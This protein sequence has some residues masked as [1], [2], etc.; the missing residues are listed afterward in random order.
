MVKKG[1]SLL[2]HVGRSRLGRRFS[3]RTL[4]TMLTAHFDESCGGGFVV[5]GGWI[6]SVEEWDRFE[7]DWKLFLIDYK[8]PYLHMKE[9][10][11]SVGPYKKW[12]DSPHFRARFLHDAWE[13]IRPCVRNGFVSY[14]QDVLFNRINHSYQLK[15]NVPSPYAFEGR[16]CMDWADK[17]A[18]ESREEVRCIFEDVA[19]QR[20][21]YKGNEY[22]SLPSGTIF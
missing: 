17:F 5:V 11:H 3:P 14:G 9:Y 4:F 10:A 18:L 8:V 1:Y 19:R 6:A 15:E 2:E 13:V 12:K 20:R 21:P 7:I 16:E 22:Q